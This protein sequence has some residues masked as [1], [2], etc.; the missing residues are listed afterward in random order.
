MSNHL[1]KQFC[2]FFA[3]ALLISCTKEKPGTFVPVPVDP[4]PGQGPVINPPQSDPPFWTDLINVIPGAKVVGNLS[5][6][7]VDLA[8][9]VCN[10]KFYYAADNRLEIFDPVSET[11]VVKSFDFGRAF[12]SAAS[13]GNKVIFAGGFNYDP[14][15]LTTTPSA[16][17]N[18][19]DTDKD[20]WA[21]HHLSIARFGITTFTYEDEVFFAGG[22]INSQTL[23]PRRIDIYNISSD[24]WS[25]HH[26]SDYGIPV[27]TVVGNK[28]WFVLSGTNKIDVYDPISKTWTATLI[29]PTIYGTTAVNISNKIYFAGSE[30]VNVYDISS[31]T[32]S[33]LTL[34]ERKFSIPVGVSNNKIAFIGGMTSWGVYSTKIEIYDP[35]KNEWSYLFMNADLY[36]QAIIS[37]NDY[38]YSAGGFIN[39]E[40]TM[41]SEIYRF[42]L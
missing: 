35:A 20:T 26:L 29:P 38:I 30:V 9:T 14:G 15:N 21:T 19:Y 10:N 2:C 31:D 23:P 8:S 34:S 42:S 32:W 5:V 25:I 3:A 6:P 28:I 39:Y 33:V 22:G 24:S 12:M 18:I 37:H 4:Q 7:G 1:R 36:Y 11:A 13:C 40:N 17:V 27:I 41:L 16:K